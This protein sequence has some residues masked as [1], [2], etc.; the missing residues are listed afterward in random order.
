MINYKENLT[1]NVIMVYSLKKNFGLQNEKKVSCY[2]NNFKLQFNFHLWKSSNLQEPN[3]TKK[4]LGVL[5]SNFTVTDI[6][7]T[8]YYTFYGEK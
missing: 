3:I 6:I 8:I 7:M 2:T 4:H 5:Y 1:A